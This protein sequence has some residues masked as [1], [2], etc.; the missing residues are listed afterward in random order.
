MLGTGARANELRSKP[1]QNTNPSARGWPPTNSP[2]GNGCQS[3]VLRTQTANF[4]TLR[5][6]CSL[7]GAHPVSE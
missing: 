2:V 4:Q 7:V 5:P 3:E 6:I 1:N